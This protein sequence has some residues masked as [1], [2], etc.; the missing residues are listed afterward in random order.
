[1]TLKALSFATWALVAS[2]LPATTLAAPRPKSPWVQKYGHPWGK[3]HQ[4]REAET[5]ALPYIPVAAPL[6]NVFQ[7]LSTSEAV[8]VTGFLHQQSELNLTAAENATR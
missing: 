3:S 2:T 7:E 8:S 1:M 6:P 4:K 5:E